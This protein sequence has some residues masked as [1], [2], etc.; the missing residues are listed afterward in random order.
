MQHIFSFLG[1]LVV[2]LLIEACAENNSFIIFAF[3]NESK[4]SSHVAG[5]NRGGIVCLSAG[6]MKSL[7]SFHQSFDVRVSESANF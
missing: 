1:N 5:L 3:K 2:W 4:T 6:E 7:R